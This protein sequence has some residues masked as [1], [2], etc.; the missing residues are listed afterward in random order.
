MV[1]IA[2]NLISTIFVGLI[3]NKIFESILFMATYIPIEFMLVDITQ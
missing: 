2:L 3:F 1:F